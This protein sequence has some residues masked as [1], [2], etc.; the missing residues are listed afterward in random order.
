MTLFAQH[1]QPSDKHFWYSMETTAVP[2]KIW[3]IWA[4]VPNWNQWDTGL[5]SAE[6]SEKLALNATGIITSLEGRKSKFRIVAFEEGKSYTFK[7]RLPL[8]ALH[9]KRYLETKNGKTV[10]THDVR[11]SGITGGLFAKKF[12]PKFREMLPEVLKRIN[13]IAGE[14]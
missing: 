10:F 9:V 14:K 6:L 8:G 1:N 7:T 3:Q 13:E 4:D 5:Q 11:F 2:E 12:G